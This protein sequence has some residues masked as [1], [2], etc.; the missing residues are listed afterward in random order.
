MSSDEFLVFC[1]EEQFE[2]QFNCFKYI[3]GLIMISIKLKRAAYIL[4][5]SGGGGCKNIVVFVSIR[6]RDLNATSLDRTFLKHCTSTPIQLIISGFINRANLYNLRI[7]QSCKSAKYV[8]I[9]QTF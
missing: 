8:L 4:A 7:Y 2:N 9:R 5:S 1:C 6:Y 3:R